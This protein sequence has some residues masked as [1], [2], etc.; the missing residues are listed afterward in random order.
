MLIF[1]IIERIYVISA[2]KQVLKRSTSI[3][4]F[5]LID[6]AFEVWSKLLQDLK[7]RDNHTRSR[8]AQ[9]LSYFAISDPE[10]RGKVKD[11]LIQDVLTQIGSKNHPNQKE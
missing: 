7:N 9:F 3:I 2:D 4:Q 5:G 1:I 6:W 10:K 11:A 8:V